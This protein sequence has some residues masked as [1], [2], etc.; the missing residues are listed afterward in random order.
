[1]VRFPAIRCSTRLNK[2]AA[3][4]V[5]G[6]RPEQS[7]SMKILHADWLERRDIRIVILLALTYYLLYSIPCLQTHHSAL[8]S[9]LM[10]YGQQSLDWLQL[11]P[12][13]SSSSVIFRK[14]KMF[15]V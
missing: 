10:S 2:L 14:I 13:I 8:H 11:R 7:T 12:R 6:F 3:G 4:T 15:S 5:S 1:M 9:R